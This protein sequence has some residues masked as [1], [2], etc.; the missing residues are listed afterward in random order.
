M[1]R[2]P[3]TDLLH[4]NEEF[5]AS[6]VISR[7]HVSPAG[8]LRWKVRF[9]SGLRPNITIVA[10]MQEDDLAIHDY[11]F[12]PGST[13]APPPICASRRRTVSCSTLI[14]SIRWRRFSI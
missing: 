1:R 12:F 9:E 5:T 8:S 14:A 13:S 10:R 6:L 2:D 3:I 7:C 11:Y 4:I